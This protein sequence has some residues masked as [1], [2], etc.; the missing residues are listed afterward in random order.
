[1]VEEKGKRGEEEIEK[2]EGERGRE[3]GERG[4]MVWL[5]RLLWAG[6]EE[7]G[8]RGVEGWIK[9]R[10]VVGWQ[11]QMGDGFGDWGGYLYIVAYL[12]GRVEWRDRGC[13]IRSFRYF[14]PIPSL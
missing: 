2:R 6:K 7:D 3:K 8:E 1:M 5:R 10:L 9:A 12:H 13:L 14:T 11:V 4:G